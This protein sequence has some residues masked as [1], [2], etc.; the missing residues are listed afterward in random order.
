MISLRSVYKSQSYYYS[1]QKLE[2]KFKKITAPLMIAM[3][4]KMLRIKINKRCLRPFQRKLQNIP[5][6]Y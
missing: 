3:K 1:V 2:N 6:S 4:H 5:D